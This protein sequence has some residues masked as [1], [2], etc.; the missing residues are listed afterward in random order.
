MTMGSQ[1]RAAGA[2]ALALFLCACSQSEEEAP[3]PAPR[4]VLTTVLAESDPQALGYSGTVEPRFT[5]QLAFRTLGRIVSRE[6][7]VGDL[8][9]K[10][11]PVAAIDAETLDADLR[12][13]EA[14]VD[15][16][17][18]QDRNARAAFERTKRLFA[19][20]T[21]AQSEVDNA[22]QSLSAAEAQLVSA[23]AQLAKAQ[24]SLSYAVLNAPFDGVITN[25]AA[26]VGQVVSAGE[27]VMTL[28]RT[29]QREAV[30]DVPAE[31]A[32]EVSVGSPFAVVLQIAP[33]V[34]A[35]GKV[36][37]IAPQADTLTRTVRMRI[38]LDDPQSAFRLGA[39]ITAIPAAK[40]G[41]PVIFLPPSA[42][43]EEDGK[44]SVWIVGETDGTVHK[45]DVVIERDGGGRVILVS[46]AKVGAEVVTA[47]V[48][49]L[50]EGQKVSL[51]KGPQS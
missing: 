3:P 20:K 33:S 46:G 4:P 21:V 28:A 48:H 35:D 22:Q 37:E 32:G 36:R 26:D 13:A 18:I 50:K 34:K 29:D 10:G 17:E 16:A 11:E 49:S 51:T 40:A 19:E 43:F 7:D 44:T 27:E 39:L 24:N 42:V 5:T 41:K 1:L 31:R 15:S 8:V 23:K 47:G 25:R 9:E 38:S 12:S 45:Q 6:V 30:I 14:Q 2:L